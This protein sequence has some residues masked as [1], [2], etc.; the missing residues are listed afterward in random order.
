VTKTKKE[1]RLPNNT[2]VAKF[3]SA[4]FKKATEITEYVKSEV[5]SIFKRHG[6]KGRYFV[7][8]GKE[9]GWRAGTAG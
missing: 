2:F 1:V 6:V 9:W 4:S 8:A 3:G 5:S 7:V